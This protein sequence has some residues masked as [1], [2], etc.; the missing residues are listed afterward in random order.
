MRGS[1]TSGSPGG[2]EKL[3]A[4]LWICCQGRKINDINVLVAGT[5]WAEGL[6]KRFTQPAIVEF[7]FLAEIK[8]AA[9]KTILSFAAGGCR[10]GQP[11]APKRPECVLHNLSPFFRM[12]ASRPHHAAEFLRRHPHGV[13]PIS[14]EGCK[15]RLYNGAAVLFRL[16]IEPVKSMT[17]DVH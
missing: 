16:G 14:V 11:H 13:R 17:P 2:A 6:I 4:C 7:C 15:E 5:F 1:V 10:I 3:G 9:Q 8:P 12:I